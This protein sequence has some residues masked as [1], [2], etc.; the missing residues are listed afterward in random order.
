VELWLRH[1][2]GDMDRARRDLRCYNH[3][4]AEKDQIPVKND[5]FRMELANFAVADLFVQLNP[6]S[7]VIA[8]NFTLKYDFRVLWHH[9]CAALCSYNKNKT[10][11]EIELSILTEQPAKAVAEPNP[12]LRVATDPYGAM[13]ETYFTDVP[14]TLSP[15]LYQV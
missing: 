9:A 6:V 7:L 2:L 1:Y 10:T 8:I 4:G 5:D 13:G 12:Y 3:T 15:E 14:A 11:Q